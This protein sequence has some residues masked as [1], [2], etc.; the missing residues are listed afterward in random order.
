MR[1]LALIAVLVAPAT[2]AAQ[3]TGTPVFA[4][5]YRA[6]RTSEIGVSLSDMNP[7]TPLEAFYKSGHGTWDIGFRGGF[8]D[9]GSG[10]SSTAILLGVD[11]RT[12]VITHDQN[13]PLDAALTLG[14]GAQL[15][16]NFN[17]FMIPVGLWLG[18]RLDLEG[19]H[20]RR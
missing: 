17:S 12:R 13:F 6:F 1:K 7:R 11:G 5:P 19:R 18:R 10:S 8:W 9:A 2:A 3:S 15:L 16:D 4:A 20:D 14:A